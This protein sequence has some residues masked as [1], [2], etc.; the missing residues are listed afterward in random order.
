[1]SRSSQSVR[2]AGGAIG[3][4][5]LAWA[6]AVPPSPPRAAA[7]PPM[8]GELPPELRY[9]PGDA[10]LF[11][12]ADAAKLWGSPV[13]ASIRQIDP[14]TFD[15]LTAEAKKELGLAPEDV[16]SVVVFVPRLMNPIDLESIG[17]VVTF[18]RDIDKE[19]LQKGAE[20]LLP[21]SENPTVHAPDART[22]VVLLNLKDEFARPQPLA[23]DAPLAPALKAA[24]GGKHVAVVGANLANFPDEIRADDV[25]PAV[26]PFQPLLRAR[27]VTATLDLTKAAATLDVRVRAATAAAA[28]DCEKALGAL[29]ALAQEEIAEGVKEFEP[30]AAKEP[31][32]KDAVTVLKAIGK[33]AGEATFA[34]DGTE[35]RMTATLPLDL[36]FASAYV[37]AKKKVEE[38]AAAATSTNNLKQIGLAMHNYHDTHGTMPPAAVC[39]K[40]GKPLLSWRVLILPYIEQDDLYRQFKLDEPWD[41]EHNK[42]LL[43][44]M[45]KTYAIPGKTPAGGTDTHYRVFVGNGAGFDWIKG[46]SLVQFTDGT[47]NTLLCVTAAD[48]VPWTKPDELAFD[49]EKDMTRLVGLVANGRLQ[50]LMG[51][52]SVRSTNKIPGKEVLHALITRGGGEVIPDFE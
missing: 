38:A 8:G 49:P 25:P 29:V 30:A 1:M 22:A 34:A 24:A 40:T 16:K 35:A 15:R 39:D 48:A 19:Q 32:L 14:N 28:I 41:S 36:P 23:A 10:A 46:H 21:G 17:I 3:L 43:A 2:I 42:K 27:T 7:Q 44:K 6:A 26:R 33:A 37:A 52:G 12:Y 13:L 18:N 4:V 45:P 5:A 31:G 47:S 20:K 50:F 9:V 11:V 51:D